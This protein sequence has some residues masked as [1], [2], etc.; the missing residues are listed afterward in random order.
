M[1]EV[2]KG[3]TFFLFW[4]QRVQVWRMQFPAEQRMILVQETNADDRRFFKIEL[5][6]KRHLYEN[7]FLLSLSTIQNATGYFFTNIFIPNNYGRDSFETQ[8]FFMI[9]ADYDGNES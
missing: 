9:G 6:L 1:Q 8:I 3:P 7:C 4:K 5:Y 2:G